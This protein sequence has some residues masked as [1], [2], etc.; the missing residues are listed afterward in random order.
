MK[1]IFLLLFLTLA[2]LQAC[3]LDLAPENV[4]VDQ[5]VYAHA[6]TT[7]AALTGA[8]VRMNIFLGG[9]PEDQNN[10]SHLSYC[11]IAGEVGTENLKVREGAT[12]DCVA[13]EECTYDNKTR[14][15]AILSTWIKGYNAI[16]YANNIIDGVTRFGAF[17]EELMAQYVA[18]ARFIRAF[19]YLNLLK[20]FG[21]GALTGNDEGLGMILRDKPYD[22]YNPDQIM[23]RSTVGDTWKF[24]L[25][26]LEAAL[27]A[28]PDRPGT[29]ETR[30]VATKPV[31]WALLS[32][33]WLYKGSYKNDKD[34]MTK[35]AEYARKVLD[36]G[37][38]SISTAFL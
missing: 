37:A 5:N 36:S 28:L 4:M 17:E 20:M 2:G 38:Y 26:D 25:T 18:E 11:W 7:R 1:K 35:A 14:D 10:Y 22:G 9:A 31:V 3:N 27:D 16:D 29:P 12:S 23:A 19:V 33:A 30:C 21:D 8:Y 15:G 6:K 32:R 13:L 34:A 24:I